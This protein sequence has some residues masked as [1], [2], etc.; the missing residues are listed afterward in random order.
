MDTPS[1]FGRELWGGREAF[2]PNQIFRQG[3][4]YLATPSMDQG[5]YSHLYGGTRSGPADDWH[6]EAFH[7]ASV[8]VTSS[9]FMPQP[10]KTMYQYLTVVKGMG[11]QIEEALAQYHDSIYPKSPQQRLRAVEWL[12]EEMEEARDQSVYTDNTVQDR[13]VWEL[14]LNTLENLGIMYDAILGAAQQRHES[15]GYK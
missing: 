7:D 9:E 10:Y 12:E 5:R 6:H 13:R 11:I 1:A 15:L 8:Q 3:K 14:Y 4:S 2:E